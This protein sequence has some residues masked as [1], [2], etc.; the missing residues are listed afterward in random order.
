MN[1]KK[2]T[3][4]KTF[5]GRLLAGAVSLGS[6]LSPGIIGTIAQATGLSD[7]PM[8]KEALSKEKLSE[9]DLNFL[10]KELDADMQEMQEVTKRWSLDSISEDWLPRNVRPITLIYLLIVMTV[11]MIL[12]SALKTFEVKA[13]WVDLIKQ[14][15][16]VVFGGYFGVRSIEKVMK[17]YKG[18]K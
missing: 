9:Q 13:H 3:K 8:L 15:L 6:K 7:V 4:K 17:I 11:L 2:P 14:L 18:V 12:D 10:L 1:D 5:F 16:L